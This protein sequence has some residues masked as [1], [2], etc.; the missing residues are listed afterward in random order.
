LIALGVMDEAIGTSLAN[1][2]FSIPERRFGTC[3]AFNSVVMG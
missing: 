3:D 1:H 2:I